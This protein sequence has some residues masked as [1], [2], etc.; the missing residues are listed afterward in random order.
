MGYIP[1]WI[2]G[3]LTIAHVGYFQK[4]DPSL[5]LC[6]SNLDLKKDPSLTFLE[7]STLLPCW[8]SS[9]V[10]RRI[11][12]APCFPEAM[13]FRTL[14]PKP[15]VYTNPYTIWGFPKI[16]GTLCRAPIKFFG[17]YTGVPLFRE[18]TIFQCAFRPLWRYFPH[19]EQTDCRGTPFKTGVCRAPTRLRGGLRV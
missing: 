16:R 2:L 8:F 9:G 11:K 15:R 17:V 4:L 7:T 5:K 13:G 14:N 10:R 6:P 18:T 1:K 19:L 12:T 3:V